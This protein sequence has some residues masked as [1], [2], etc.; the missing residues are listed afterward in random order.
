MTTEIQPWIAGGCVVLGLLMTSL[1]VFGILRFSDIYQRIQAA[2]SAIFLG[3]VPILLAI[4]IRGDGE[5]IARA[6]LIGIFLLLTAPVSSHAI[7]RGAY[8]M[9]ESGDSPHPSAEEKGDA[10][11]RKGLA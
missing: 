9:N 10:G 2:G 3:V 11:N 8:L 1:A 7:A 6:V 5:M 4:V